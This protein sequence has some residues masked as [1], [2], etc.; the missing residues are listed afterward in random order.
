MKKIIVS[1]TALLFAGIGVFAQQPLPADVQASVTRGEK[2]YTLYCL[3]CHQKSGKGVPHMNPPLTQTSYVSGDKVKLV[4]WVLKGSTEKA[5]IDGKSYS[6][7]MPA[8]NY[9][10]DDQ[11]ADV[12]TYV[13]TSFGNSYPAIT[14]DDVKG[15]RAG[16]K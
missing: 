13:R 12:L 8:Q 6:N 3:A 5:D 10:K 4:S 7:N 9:L 16:L 11:I 1:I 14:A 15:I 2:L